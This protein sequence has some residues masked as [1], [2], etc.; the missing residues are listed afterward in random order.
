MRHTFLTSLAAGLLV[1]LVA[2]A[3]GIQV[4]IDGQA[5]TFVDVSQSAWFA[6]YVQAAAETG[7]VNGYK[8]IYGKLTGKFG[9]QNNITLAEALKITVEG[10]GYDEQLYG[11]MVDSG[12]KNYWASP[13]VSVAKA[14]HFV[15]LPDRIRLDRPATRAEVASFFTSAFGIH[16]GDVSPVDSRYTDVKTSTEYA[17]S[18]EV[19]SRDG[20]LSGDT[21]IQG[22]AT[23]TFRPTERINRAEVV[24][25]VIEARAQYGQPGTDKRPPEQS[26][27]DIVGYTSE[28]FTPA[29]LHVKPGTTVTFKN[30]SGEMLWVASNPH[31]A[32]TGYGGFDAGRTSGQG[33][34][35]LFTFNRIGTFSYHNHL[36]PSLTGT[37]I[38][39]Q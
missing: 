39:E 32:H 33:G 13:Y 14:E 6:T 16:L 17:T 15:F 22:Q 23:G 31:P 36:R 2:G 38:V 9:P 5:V 3:A 29:V 18:I 30:D 1:P 34:V 21:D 11:S 37:I 25:M 8:D 12:M 7:I 26:E 20:V 27:T 10:A 19:L 35:Y 28:G 4:M 24:K